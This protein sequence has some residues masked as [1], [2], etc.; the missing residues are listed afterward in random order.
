MTFRTNRR[1]KRKFW[2]SA[3]RKWVDAKTDFLIDEEDKSPKQ[4]YAIAISLARKKGYKIPKRKARP[5]KKSSYVLFG[6]VASE[7]SKRAAP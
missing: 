1:T 4:A 6:N 7:I 3:A 5:K 2:S